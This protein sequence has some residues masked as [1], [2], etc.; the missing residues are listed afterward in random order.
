MKKVLVIG[1]TG[2]LG[3]AVTREFYNRGYW[4][5]ALVRDAGRLQD[6][7]AVINDIVTGE[8]ADSSLLERACFGVDVVFSCLGSPISLSL[9]KQGTSH[10]DVDYALNKRLLNAAMRANISKFVYVSMFG[11]E[12][13]RHLEYV[14]AQ[15]DFVDDLK[16]SGIKYAV[17]CPT[18][19]FYS[20]AD[21]VRLA[22][23]PVMV[24]IGDGE[25]HTNPIHE[26]DLAI[27]CGDAIEGEQTE[28]AVGGQE[29]YTRKQIN[30]LA[31]AALGKKSRMIKVPPSLVKAGLRIVQPFN[32]RLYE[33]LA[34]LVSVT[35]VECVAPPTGTRS[36]ESYYAEVAKRYQG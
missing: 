20:L 14:R 1:A 27:V 13:L 29:I 22:R 28:Y 16:R 32:Q 24:L 26:D 34:F 9:A 17:I 21:L 7:R 23:N 18:G 3:K 36:L 2:H 15:E 31:F 11:A 4:I 10:R 19:F 33:L 30:E 5:R 6:T 25:K 12:K 8:V 35:Q